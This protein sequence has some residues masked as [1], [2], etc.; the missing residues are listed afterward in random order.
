MSNARKLNVALNAQSKT[1]RTK[2][3]EVIE[4]TL[5][6]SAAADAKYVAVQNGDDLILYF[7][8]GTVVTLDGYYANDVS[9]T[10]KGRTM[11]EPVMETVAGFA[12]E[13]FD[14]RVVD[15]NGDYETL[16]A[17][18]Q[19]KGVQAEWPDM[20]DIGIGYVPGPIAIGLGAGALAGFVSD[21]SGSG[22]AASGDAASGWAVSGTIVAGPV[23]P[24]HDLLINIYDAEG[25]LL[26]DS[27]IVVADDGS[28][29]FT[30]STSYA[31]PVLLIAYSAGDNPDYHDEATNTAINLENAIAAV[32]EVAA[33]DSLTINLTP[34]STMAVAEL[35]VDL[36]A[37]GPDATT[38][39]ISSAIAGTAVTAA[40][41]KIA[42]AFGMTVDEFMGEILPVFEIDEDGIAVRVD[43]N[44]YGQVLA[45]LSGLD[46]V[47][48]KTLSQG[49][50]D[51]LGQINS[52]NE[53]TEL[54]QGLVLQG[55]MAAETE[56][57]ITVADVTELLVPDVA[58]RATA[59][60][61]ALDGVIA[62]T[63]SLAAALGL[64]S[65]IVM[66]YLTN[67]QVAAIEIEAL[68][69]FK[70]GLL[71]GVTV[72]TLQFWQQ[73][74]SDVDLLAELGDVVNALSPDQ[75]E[76]IAA[77]PGTL[78][79]IDGQVVAGPVLED[80][81]LIINAFSVI[82]GKRVSADVVEIDTDGSF[83]MTIPNYIGPV[84]FVL[85]TESEQP[86]YIDEALGEAVNLSGAVAAIANIV[87]GQQSVSVTPLSTLAALQLQM[88]LLGISGDAEAVA[89]QKVATSQDVTDAIAKVT[90]AFGLT[91]DQYNADIIPT[92]ELDANN[93]VVA[94]E[95]A[96]TYGLILA[97]LAGFD[98]SDDANLTEG[99]VE[100]ANQIILNEETGNYELSIEGQGLILRG[101]DA[102]AER[103]SISVQDIARIIDP[104]A[105]TTAASFT[106][107]DIATLKPAIAAF[108]SAETIAALDAETLAQVDGDALSVLDGEGLSQWQTAN[109]DQNILTVLGDKVTK[110]TGG[111]MGTL[112]TAQP[113]LAADLDA[114]VL[115][116]LAPSAIAK[117]PATMI[118]NLPVEKLTAMK[119][120][121]LRALSADQL[122]ALSTEQLTALA[123]EQLSG[124]RAAQVAGMSAEQFDTLSDTQLMSIARSGGLRAVDGDAV[125][126][127]DAVY[128]PYVSGAQLGN[129]DATQLGSLT[130]EQISNLNAAQMEYLNIATVDPEYADIVKQAIA[131]GVTLPISSWDDVATAVTDALAA[132]DAMKAVLA[133]TSTD[134]T[135]EQLAFSGLD[136]DALSDIADA[137]LQAALPLIVELL[138]EATISDA[139][140]LAAAFDALETLLIAQ[141]GGTAELTYMQLRALDLDAE[142][143]ASSHAQTRASLPILTDLLA[144]TT[145]TSRADMLALLDAVA[146]GFALTKGDDTV[147]ITQAELE[148]LGYDF[149]DVGFT[150]DELAVMLPFV[151]DLMAVDVTTGAE[152]TDLVA[153]V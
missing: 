66:P 125:A 100:L 108:L 131:D 96:N 39:N 98:Y 45:V 75:R 50:T 46:L 112:L 6:G 97:A 116:S 16:E 67:E 77:T 89:L 62:G 43:G 51:L 150:A 95:D 47:D 118:E 142:F 63:G 23:T 107:D 86:D 110:V 101:A 59:A 3:G 36:S 21:G 37:Y 28:F 84:V 87:E 57:G 29:E 31:G 151:G 153:A 53:L 20:V 64:I 93:N 115:V 9:L 58:A 52:S 99:L 65:P 138:S 145:I 104:D 127:L 17:L 33:G 27:A 120:S 13:G 148:L 128:M 76:A 82:S 109:A 114:D 4:I 35:G 83:D 55:A 14:V 73:E 8:D 61:T 12:S 92:V 38:L 136:L 34:L 5:K 68:T 88:D 2:A 130:I 15:F 121:Q 7:T 146:K 69:L 123:P 40:M 48:G 143:L 102:A 60:A 74:N 49:L 133:G 124:L 122:G 56:T 26:N 126:A 144:D 113:E 41:T 106:A 117:L 42:S 111:Q 147:E 80:S 10:V 78:A 141:N 149:T 70:G 139:T 72:E 79:Q 103:S 18:L 25:N 32:A 135:V 30:N 134:I 71:K 129:L 81:D 91:V 22:D 85:T 90:E 119:P 24:N 137:D 132:I 105:E 44:K 54:G 1:I 152:L 11:P 140:Q 19:G 94:N